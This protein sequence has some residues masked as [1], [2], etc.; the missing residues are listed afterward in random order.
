MAAPSG[1]TTS[2]G[3]AAL[4]IGLGVG[5]GLSFLL[6]AAAG[7]YCYYTKAKKPPVVAQPVDVSSS[8]TAPSTNP[9]EKV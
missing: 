8:T 3:G 7:A 6:L 9:D 4:G 2:G 1:T 5:L